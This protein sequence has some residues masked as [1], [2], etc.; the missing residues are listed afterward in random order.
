MLRPSRRDILKLGAASCLTAVGST[1]TACGSG[2]NIGPSAAPGAGSRVYVVPGNSLDDLGP[3]ARQATQ[4]LGI[5]RGSLTGSSVFVKPNL[6]SVGT[7]PFDPHAGEVTKPE[8]LLGIAEQCLDAGARRVTIGDGAQVMLWDYSEIGFLHGKKLAGA[9]HLE[10][11]VERL[12]NVYGTSR[13]ELLCLNLQDEWAPIPSSSSSP[14]LRNGLLVAKSFHDAD[15]VISAPVL[16]SHVFV[17]ISGALMNYVGLTP[18]HTLGSGGVIRS[19]LHQAYAEAP[20]AGFDKAG[21]AGAFLDICAWRK[22]EGKQDFAIVD[23]SL[24]VEGNGPLTRGI[25]DG[26]TIDLRARSAMGQYYLLASDDLV[27]ADS[28]AAQVMGFHENETQ[29]LQMASWLGLGQSAKIQV[30]GA[31]LDEIRVPDFRRAVRFDEAMI[32]LLG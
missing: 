30:V 5:T 25:F 19:L 6:V 14:L 9:A 26:Q 17:G 8:V 29:H 20:L 24:G 28:I 10:A 15:H 21:I 32:Q 31:S 23:C 1:L 18:L 4:K 16:K 3:M 22:S 13:V 7:F 27:A 12:Q 2:S 11:G